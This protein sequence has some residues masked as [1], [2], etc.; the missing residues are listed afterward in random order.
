MERRHFLK[1]GAT[2]MGAIPFLHLDSFNLPNGLKF[3][4]T[5]I[6]RLKIGQCE[7]TILRDLVMS[8]TSQDFFLNVNA[9]ELDPALRRFG[10]DPANIPSP[11]IVL[12]LQYDDR[13]VLIDTGVGY[14]EQ[15]IMIGGNP[16]EKKGRLQHL[17]A[18]ENLKKEDI[19]DVILSHFHPDHIGGI[20]NENK[21]PV[22]PNAKYHA[23]LEEWDYWHSSLADNQSP[24]FKFFIADQVTPLKDRDLNLFTGDYSEILPGIIA[25]QAFGHTPGHVALD[26]KFENEHLLYVSDAFLHP[27]HIERLDWQTKYDMD[28]DQARKSREKLLDL[29]YRENMLVN[30]F[31]FDFP[32]LGNIGKEGK[33]WKWIQKV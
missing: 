15:P 7:V 23:P 27:L 9:Q 22:F 16:F 25:V 2:I 20:F 11:F 8:Y 19:T 30:V 28:H 3:F 24:F 12:L 13:K 26:L 32:G 14:T 17:L 33:N 18:S 10:A 6:S 31:H 4:D 5:E 29:A 1:T 21:D